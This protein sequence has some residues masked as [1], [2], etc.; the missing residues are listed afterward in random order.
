MLIIHIIISNL[1]KK[2]VKKNNATSNGTS[3]NTHNFEVHIKLHKD[4]KI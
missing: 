2:I 1:Y 4:P 3:I